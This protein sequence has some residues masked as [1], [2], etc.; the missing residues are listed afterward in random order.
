[1]TLV[2]ADGT[3]ARSGGHVIKNVAGYDLAKLVHG[4]LGSL[5]LVAEVVVRLHPRPTTSTTTAGAADAAQATAAALA[6]AASPLEP[7]AVEWMSGS[8]GQLLVRIDGTAASVQDSSQRLVDL[9]TAAAGWTPLRLAPE[10]TG[11]AWQAHAAAVLGEEDETTLRV[12]G[13]PA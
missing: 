5:A 2:L 7:S 8:P 13:R 4:S 12:A 3:V 1:M 9:L 11:P 10:E 6:L